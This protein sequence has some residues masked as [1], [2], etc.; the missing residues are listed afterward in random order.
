MRRN[1]KSWCA[2]VGTKGRGSRLL[3]ERI[4]AIAIELVVFTVR[5]IYYILISKFSYEAG[6]RFYKKVVYRVGKL[7]RLHPWLHARIVDRTRIVIEPPEP[8]GIEIWCEKDFIGIIRDI[9][10]RF[11]A[12]IVLL[13]GFPSLSALRDALERARRRGKLI[14][15]YIGDFDPSGLLIDRVSERE[16]GIP[17]RR[18]ALTWEQIQ[19]YRLPS[20]PV[21]RRD[22]RAKE[23]IRRYG[24]RC[25]EIEAMPPDLLRRIL[26][27]ELRRL[28]PREVLERRERKLQA[29][30][31]VEGVL[32]G[33]AARLEA[34]AVELLEAGWSEAEIVHS[35]ES[36]LSRL[37]AW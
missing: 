14:V 22:S 17:I 35:F 13:H 21:N 2:W 1:S 28:V 3:E 20:V 27:R 26:E 16:T 19:R 37:L 34:E 23:Y 30:R 10:M 18:I 33:L 36:K 32:A 4:L 31:L 6:H 7:R 11:G 15:L 29:R 8:T 25:W 5:H 12:S 24:D 9:A